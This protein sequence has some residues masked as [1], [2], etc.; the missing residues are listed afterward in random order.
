MHFD[1]VLTLLGARGGR[2]AG[3]SEDRALL[4]EATLELDEE[5][6]STPEGIEV[7]LRDR[8][9]DPVV[10]AAFIEAVA[11]NVSPHNEAAVE[12]LVTKV[13]HDAP[14]EE[15]APIV[16]TVFIAIGAMFIRSR[17]APSDAILRADHP[18][19]F[20]QQ[21]LDPGAAN[22]GCLGGREG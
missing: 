14:V 5:V 20:G 3:G 9:T 10:A 6:L 1:D 15:R 8:S 18:G 7:I 4:L 22:R 11:E 12:A 21:G 19:G 2:P 17:E 13:E 16:T